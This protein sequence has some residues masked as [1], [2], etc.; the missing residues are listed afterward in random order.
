MTEPGAVSAAPAAAESFERMTMLQLAEF[1]LAELVHPCVLSTGELAGK[2]VIV[3]D[4]RQVAGV[5]QFAKLVAI[6]AQHDAVIRDAVKR[7][8]YGRVA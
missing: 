3:L 5:E 7:A 1:V 4:A 2:T 8:S 6:F